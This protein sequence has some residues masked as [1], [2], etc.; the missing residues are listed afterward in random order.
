MA[1]LLK[2]AKDFADDLTT[3]HVIRRN[4]GC[5][6]WIRTMTRASKELGATITPPDN[7]A[8]QISDRR[9]KGKH[10]YDLGF[11]IWIL[12]PNKTP[13]EVLTAQHDFRRSD[14]ERSPQER[15]N[16]KSEIPNTPKPYQTSTGP[17]G[18]G[19]A[20]R[21]ATAGSRMKLA[22]IGTG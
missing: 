5:P 1:V 14:R 21:L 18:T 10:I 20:S 3:V 9:E 11:G 22:T 17:L 6:A 16:R 13:L 4:S 19:I 15:V 12:A 8:G 7:N 2:H